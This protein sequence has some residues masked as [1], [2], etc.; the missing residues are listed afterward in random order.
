[1]DV[2]AFSNYHSH[3]NS[4]R[5][6]KGFFWALVLLPLVRRAMVREEAMRYLLL[7]MLVGLVGVAVSVIWERYLFGGVFNFS[8]NFRVTGTFSAMHV[9]GGAIGAYL[10]ASLPFSIGWL[11]SRQ[12][13]VEVLVGLAV[14]GIGLY[15]LLVTF[16]RAG[17]L[18]FAIA[19]MV[20]SAGWCFS[21]ARVGRSSFRPGRWSL[22][23]VGAVIVGVAIPV[24][25]GT[26]ATSR[27]ANVGSD[28]ASRI[29]HWSEVMDMT[30]TGWRSTM[31]GVGLGRFPETYLWKSRKEPLPGTYRFE[32]KGDDRSLLL[33]SGDALYFGQRVPIRPAT[34]YTLALRLRGTVKDSALS[35]PIC[36]KALLYSYECKWFRIPLRRADD[37][38][39]SHHV[40]FDSASL[41]SGPWYARRPIELALYNAAAD[42][43]LAVDDV[44]L[45]EKSDT[46]LISNGSFSSGIDHWFFAVDNH[47]PWH[48]ENI[49]LA[50]YF[51]QGVLGVIAF[52]WLVI[53]V[54]MTLVR[55][56][57]EGHEC[58]VYLLASIAA[59][60]TVGMLSSLFEFPR[61]A[62]LFYLLV[63]VVLTGEKR[64][65]ATSSNAIRS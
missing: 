5:V 63:C 49:L 38:W 52:I 2:N 7:G 40:E 42:T 28:T 18:G 51:E 27:F 26:F 4:L 61:L 45:F 50:R 57:R 22:L 33:G 48:I 9:G 58:S 3:Y 17:Y 56:I 8:D 12:K 1:L 36:E 35:V 37:N 55:R 53:Y 6:A 32:T 39:E 59:F 20:I 16:A 29:A 24:L 44:R 65:T 21:P 11:L 23:A 62:L 47:W 14:L 30:E 60:L 10:A 13:R 25:Q 64:V 43:V 19:L 54:I 34:T 41:G 46:N 15:A 31:L